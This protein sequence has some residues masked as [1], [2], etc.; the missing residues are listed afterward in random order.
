MDAVI[1]SELADL[2]SSDNSESEASGLRAKDGS[3][4]MKRSSDGYFTVP[5][6]HGRGAS[7]KSRDGMSW[8]S[9]VTAPATIRVTRLETTID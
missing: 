9:N 5:H 8:Q 3:S 2:V 4:V 1:S 6:R 7:G